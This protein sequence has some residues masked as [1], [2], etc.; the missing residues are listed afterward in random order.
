MAYNKLSELREESLDY[1]FASWLA[2]V[3]FM[4][5]P[6]NLYLVLG[7]AS[8]KTTDIIAERSMDIVY[9]MPGAQ[10]A[11]VSDTYMNAQK[12]IIPSLMEGWNRKGWIEGIHYVLDKR[13]PAK[14][15]KPYRPVAD[16]KHTIS[17][18]NGCVFKIVSMDRP[19]T[20]AGDS[21]QHL[22][23]DEVKFTRKKKID[24]LIPAIRGEYV[25]FHHS[26]FYR[27]HT[28]TT[29]M[30]DP[31]NSIFEEDWIMHLGKDMDTVQIE[32]ILQ[33]AWEVNKIRLNLLSA[34]E[35]RNAIAI[36][37]YTKLLERWE[38]RLRKIRLSS[39]FWA[40]ASSLV[41]ADMLTVDYF[42]DQLEALGLTEFLK[43]VLGMRPTLERGNRFYINLS[44]KH[45]YSDGYNY[46]YYDKFNLGSAINENSLGLKYINY[47]AALEG[48]FDAGN[49]MSLVVGQT[50]GKT[51]R[52]LKS[53]YTI[54]P[55]WIEQLGEK[56]RTFFEPHKV[57]LLHLWYDRSA[58]NYNKAGKDFAS[59]LKY[60]IE[61]K[62]GI[63]TGWTVILMS[64]NMGNVTHQQEYE[65][66]LKLM[67]GQSPGL[68]Q[69]LIDQFECRE[70][71][72][73]LE[74]APV[75]I[76]HIGEKKAIR[77]IKT[78][79][80]LP[81]ERLPLESTNFSD[82]FKAYICRPDWIR[83]ADNKSSLSFSDP[84]VL[85]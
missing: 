72:S 13:P 70:L 62:N 79:E 12:N 14:W 82:A 60:H 50:Q 6:K 71:K 26:P 9:D 41:N 44:A 27:G 66:A 45:F 83:V 46:G 52:L 73:S 1:R 63:P 67:S 21:Y 77:K 10:F 31:N 85:K 29:D 78:S 30:P 84:K 33:C 32:R 55:E 74:L 54:T 39:T 18:W 36:A 25:R 64:R 75:E 68:P 61:N 49:M 59:E 53:I 56:F 11:I 42:T 40:S 8:G 57:K 58:N 34:Q 76:K 24:K 47:N 51:T 35:E 81:I 16:Y 4:L 22:F 7:R 19:S 80:K 17:T 5:S 23:G 38:E 15:A 3:V 43:S 69:L 20:G 2:Q 48:G 28:F 37:K 65:L